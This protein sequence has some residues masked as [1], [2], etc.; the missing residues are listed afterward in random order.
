VGIQAWDISFLGHPKFGLHWIIM[1]AIN[2][3]CF[4]PCK[5]LPLDFFD[6]KDSS[7]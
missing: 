2:Q 6:V 4:S 3:G 5:G 1:K 7:R